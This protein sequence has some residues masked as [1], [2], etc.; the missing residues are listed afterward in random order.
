[1]ETKE[2]GEYNG[3]GDK[4]WRPHSGKGGPLAGKEENLVSFEHPEE[5]QTHGEVTSV[6]DAHTTTARLS[7]L[8]RLK[9]VLC[10]LREW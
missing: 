4:R 10:L 6:T 5:L 9:S 2:G 3:A 7:T 1:M 8:D